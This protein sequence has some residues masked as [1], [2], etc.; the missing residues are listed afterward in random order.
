M[1]PLGGDSV[2]NDASASGKACSSSNELPFSNLKSP[3]MMCLEA[4]LAFARQRRQ[5]HQVLPS[6]NSVG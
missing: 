1:P 6:P 4:V 2:G 5:I 3:C